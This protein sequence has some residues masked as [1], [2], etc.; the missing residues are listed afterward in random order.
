MHIAFVDYELLCEECRKGPF[1][2]RSKFQH[3]FQLNCIGSTW[4][5]V[6]QLLIVSALGI[7]YVLNCSNQ[8]PGHS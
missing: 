7:W 1:M 8:I 3:Y 6:I 2:M 4:E 5:V